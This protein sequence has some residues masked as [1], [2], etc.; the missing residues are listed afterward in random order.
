MSKWEPGLSPDDRVID[1]PPDA[2][3]DGD[4]VQDRR[5]KTIADYGGPHV[6]HPGAC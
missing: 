2:L 6:S 4:L 1:N 3:R 5:T